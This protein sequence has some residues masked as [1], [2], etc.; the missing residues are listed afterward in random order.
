[1]GKS[2]EIEETEYEKELAKVYGEEWQLYEEKIVPFENIVIKDAKEANDKAV[3]DDIAENTNLGYKKSFTEAKNNTLSSMQANG[4]NPNSGKFKQ[5]L[6]DISNN[7]ASVTSD[8]TARSQV[9]GQERYIGQMSNVMAMGQGQ[10]QE[11]T[12]TLS[13]IAQSSQRKAFNDASISQQQ[14]DN[15]LGAAGAIAGAAGSY[16]TSQPAS[17]SGSASVDDIYTS[18]NGGG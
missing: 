18:L 6:S 10:S 3:Y 11:A 14:S 5:T 4:V 1:M 8:A 15:L 17:S 13:D 16:Y 9:A 2:S 7:E 12:A